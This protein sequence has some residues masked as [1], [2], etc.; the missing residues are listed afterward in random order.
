MGEPPQKCLLP[1]LDLNHTPNRGE[2]TVQHR[3]HPVYPIIAMPSRIWVGTRRQSSTVTAPPCAESS[4][5]VYMPVTSRLFEA[6]LK[7]PAKCF[8]WSRGDTGTSNAYAGWVQAQS[9][10]YRGEGI[11]RIKHGIEGNE[12]VTGPLNGKDLKSA[13]WRLAVDSKA[14]A[15]NLESAIDA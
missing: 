13:R 2:F 6:Y 9:A 4:S 3:A 5:L 12:C 11:S 7:C 1:L 14:S 8:L 10:S 15:E